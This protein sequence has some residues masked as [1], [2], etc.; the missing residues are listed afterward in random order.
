MTFNPLNWDIIGKLKWLVVSFFA[1]IAFG[2]VMIG[3]RWATTGSYVDTAYFIFEKPIKGE[4]T[5]ITKT[6]S[7]FAM[8]AKLGNFSVNVPPADPNN[9]EINRVDIQATKIDD[10]QVKMLGENLQKSYGALKKNPLV[11]ATRI[12]GQ[13][14]NWG[15]D[16]TGGTILEITFKNPF[17]DAKEQA[18]PDEQVIGKVRDAFAKNGVPV[19]VVQV[20][21]LATEEE[22]GKNVANSILVRTQESSNAKLQ[23][24][25]EE[26][27]KTKVFG[28]QLP[29]KQRVDSIGPTI[30]A[31]LKRSAVLALIIALA[32]IFIYIAFR[33]QPRAGVAAIACLIHD[34]AFVLGILA[35]SW[36]EVNSAA[37][38]ALLAVISY[39]VQDTVVIM[40]RVR[41]NTKL[42][43]GKMPYPQL[44][45][46]S[47]TQ[48]YMRSFNTSFTTVI[49]ILV[50]LF[51]GGKTILDFSLIFFFG[52]LAGTY[53]SIYI[54]AP[55]LVVW[56]NFEERLVK[57][58]EKT[59]QLATPQGVTI[60]VR[61]QQ[62]TGKS[63]VQNNSDNYTQ[64]QLAKKGPPKKK[65]N[66]KRKR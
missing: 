20:Q 5:E 58:D 6:V 22:K 61:S 56:K 47:V 26:L 11:E 40:D 43:L 66:K 62:P 33:F 53:S 45:N 21:R 7:G 46:M 9:P 10:N 12:A 42:Y 4:I 13:P 3:F 65:S 60:Q 17:V 39:D 27:T 35:L 36:V 19:S 64:P 51:F 30:G 1:V 25:I 23:S 50:I 18:L 59:Y 34:I 48:T 57:K 28:E 15:L 16:F 52:L 49:G 31:E 37:V 54:A 24:V 44:I 55:L 63:A 8:N 38:A 32:V 41:E 2:I 29:E 14:F